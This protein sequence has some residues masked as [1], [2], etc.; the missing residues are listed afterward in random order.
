MSDTDKEKFQLSLIYGAKTFGWT[1]AI[2]AAGAVGG[3]LGPV[4]AAVGYGAGALIFGPKVYQNGRDTFLSARDHLQQTDPE[5]YGHPRPKGFDGRDLHESRGSK[6]EKSFRSTVKTAAWVAGGLAVGGL[7]VG[8]AMSGAGA[9]VYTLMLGSAA[10]FGYKIYKNVKQTA[11][12]YRSVKAHPKASKGDEKSKEHQK[13]AEKERSQTL[14]EDRNFKERQKEVQK[15]MAYAGK[16]ALTGFALM[17][18]SGIALGGGAASMVA[19]SVGWLGAGAVFGR[20]MVA[21]GKKAFGK[22]NEPEGEMRK[23]LLENQREQQRQQTRQPVV[24]KTTQKTETLQ[25][26]KKPQY[27]VKNVP[28]SVVINGGK[29]KD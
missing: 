14:E 8:M 18:L 27:T 23:H 4:G 25:K 19:A 6:I 15:T 20:G 7:L 2:V 16:F 11:A 29:G 13:T 24:Q 1:C 9:G 28:I 22:M 10:F 21:H 5:I 17:A 12:D 3:L 26:P